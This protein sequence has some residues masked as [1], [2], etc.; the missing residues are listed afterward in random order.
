MSKILTSMVSDK[1]SAQILTSRSTLG[2]TPNLDVRINTEGLSDIINFKVLI[3]K[4][5]GQPRTHMDASNVQ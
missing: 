2:L 5:L 3:T 1:P 4:L